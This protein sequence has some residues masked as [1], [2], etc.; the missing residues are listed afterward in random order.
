MGWVL[1]GVV[2]ICVLCWAFIGGWALRRKAMET[3]R[4][5][6]LAA[7]ADS[8][9]KQTEIDGLLLQ[10]ETME[11]ERNDAAV[12][13]DR[14]RKHHDQLES[15]CTEL[16]RIIDDYRRW[17]R[18]SVKL[19]PDSVKHATEIRLVEVHRPRPAEVKA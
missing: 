6:Y 18:E 8:F 5:L 10:I 9:E 11:R 16:Q 14:Y 17:M 12:D 4:E 2:C 3:F 13:W 15:R 1:I 7:D 19:M